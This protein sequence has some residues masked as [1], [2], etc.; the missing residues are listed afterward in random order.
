MNDDVMLW[1]GLFLIGHEYARLFQVGNER[2]LNG[3]A[4]FAHEGKRCR[5]D[6]AIRCDERWVT[7]RVRVC[8]WIGEEE[9]EVSIQVE[10]GGR[11]IVNG[12]HSAV[13]DGC[14]DI[15]LNFSPSTNLLPIRRL[16]AQLASEQKVSAA[17]LRFPSMTLEP[18]EQ[19]YLRLDDHHYRYTS[20]S[21]FSADLQVN[22]SGFVT[23]YP[24]I[25]VAV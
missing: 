5:L 25:W 23:D 14:I 11:W 3:V 15:D 22:D 10:P 7:K 12:A 2:H 19:S 13:V 20:A 16:G 4:L 24:D 6:Y 21:G 8:G 1:R 17:W 9:V 18:L